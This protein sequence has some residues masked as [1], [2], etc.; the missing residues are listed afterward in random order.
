MNGCFVDGPSGNMFVLVRRPRA[1]VQ[2]AVLF[3]PAFGEEMN[4]TRRTL[5]ELAIGIAMNGLAAILPDFYGTGDSGGDFSDVDPA[6]WGRDLASVVNWTSTQGL[7]VSGYVGV[8]LGCAVLV[9]A[10]E[11]GHLPAARRSVLIQPVLDGSRFLTQF[12]RLR[13]AAGLGDADRRESLSGLRTRLADGETLEIAGYTLTPRVATALEVMKMPQVL[14][15]GLG[16]TL[17]IEVGPSDPPV[18]SASLDGLL[19]RSAAAGVDIT[20]R[21]FK[22]EPFWASTESLRVPVVEDA[23]TGFLATEAAAA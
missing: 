20:A 19:S 12:L 22:G 16:A 14:P 4:K 17:A 23:A 18:L 6:K 2:R 7:M 10:V 1:A 21:V 3:V 11:S 5:T 13:V 8:R 15:S 9:N